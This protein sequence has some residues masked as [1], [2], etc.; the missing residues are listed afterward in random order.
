M[1][2][3]N[4]P[5]APFEWRSYKT[6]ELGEVAPWVEKLGRAGYFAKGLLYLIVGLSALALP[7]GMG[8]E[9]ESTSD[10]LRKIG[11]QPFGRVLLGIMAVALIGY[12]IWRLVMAVKDTEGAGT[13][14]KG[15]IKRTGYA[16]SGFVYLGL[17]FLAGKI[18]ITGGDSGGQS[19]QEQAK[20]T[21][22]STTWGQ[23][24]YI[25]IGAVVIGVAMYFI[26]KGYTAK[27]MSKYNLAQMSESVRTAALHLGR[28][29]LITRGIA[30]AIIG[31]FVVRTGLNGGSGGDVS[32]MGD[33]MDWLGSQPFGPWL[34]GTVGFGLACFGLH[35]MLMGW[36]RRFNVVWP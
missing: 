2:A 12:F 32:G 22:L 25:A 8:G 17:A 5:S 34:V 16:I 30:F 6:A 4:A 33:A 3:A 7:F 9:S 1:S 21:M 28:T 10:A 29:G 23:Y 31:W 27:F 24:L 18:A 19:T 26:Y 15:C 35:T 11:Q 14:A 36:Y 13:D 20:E